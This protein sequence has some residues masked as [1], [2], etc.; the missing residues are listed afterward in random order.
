MKRTHGSY[1]K[2]SRNLTRKARRTAVSLLKTFSEGQNVRINAS[3][4]KKEGRPFLRF[5]RLTGTIVGKQGK[6]YK[7]KVRTG[8]REKVVLVSN[9]HLEA[10]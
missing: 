7:V 2:K 6:V 1:S 8:N 10:V 4:G 9:F 3:S 5:N